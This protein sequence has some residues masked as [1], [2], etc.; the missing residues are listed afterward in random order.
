[1]TKWYHIELNYYINDTIPTNTFSTDLYLKQWHLDLS[2]PWVPCQQSNWENRWTKKIVLKLKIWEKFSPFLLD[3]HDLW[4]DQWQL[5]VYWDAQQDWNFWKKSFL[6]KIQIS[7][8]FKFQLKLLFHFEHKQFKNQ[9]KCN[10][11]FWIYAMK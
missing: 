8:S 2:V 6:G 11:H 4:L 1:M 3:D 9:K 5:E 10:T 7:D